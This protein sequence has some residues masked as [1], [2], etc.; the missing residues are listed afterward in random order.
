MSD[1]LDDVLI[2]HLISLEGWC[3]RTIRISS[4]KSLDD[5]LASEVLQ[6]AASMAVAQIG[7]VSGR[8]LKK[9]PL[10]AEGHPDLELARAVAM[11]H[12]LIHVYEQ[13]D[14]AMLWDTVQVSVPAML[15][16]V[17]QAVQESGSFEP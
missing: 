12:R 2:D 9:W 15:A 6:L 11:R 4:E 3:E 1:H 7:E 5:L 10:F 14:L 17:R 13:T 16:A 8:I